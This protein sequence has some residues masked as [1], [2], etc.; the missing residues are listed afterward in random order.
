MFI[1]CTKC[2]KRQSEGMHV[3][4]SD[5]HVLAINGRSPVCINC[6]QDS[7]AD[8]HNLDEVSNFFQVLDLVFHAEE[9]IALAEEYHKNPMMEYF[10]LYFKA[11]YERK[12]TWKQ[13]TD[14]WKTKLNVGIAAQ[15]I[16]VLREKHLVDLRIK[17]RGDYTYNDYLWLESFTEKMRQEYAVDTADENDLL[18]KIAKLSLQIDMALDK[19][20]PIKDLVIAYDKLMAIA[21]FQPASSRDGSISSISEFAD[22]METKGYVPKFHFS[23]PKDIVD[24]T[25]KDLQDFYSTLI[26]GEPNLPDIIAEKQAKKAE[27]LGI[28]VKTSEDIAYEAIGHAEDLIEEAEAM[29]AE[30]MMEEEFIPVKPEEEFFSIKDLKKLNEDAEDKI[31]DVEEEREK[32]LKEIV[33]S[34]FFNFD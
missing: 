24:A 11:G 34:D 14:L 33:E 8:Y 25:I 21:N 19:G 5:K 4:L 3:K 7:I 22:F 13:I 18:M 27:K 32:K 6:L 1:T 12:D 10:N 28:E 31:V 15:E 26:T 16:P 30:E 29:S 17:W 2:N 20:D 9:W 23:T